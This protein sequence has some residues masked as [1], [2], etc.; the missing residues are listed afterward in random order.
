MQIQADNAQLWLFPNFIKSSQAQALFKHLQTEVQ[1]QQDQL[2]M[3]GK[4]VDIPRL[5]AW[6]GEKDANYA[7]SGLTMKPLPWL[8]VLA[9]LEKSLTVQC[10]T[11][12]NNN[13]DSRA[14]NFNSALANYYRDNNDA[15]G[16][17]SDDEP[18]LG[19]NPIIASVSLGATREFKLKHKITSEKLNIP[20]TS[21]SLL[22][23][24]GETQSY[25]QHAILRSKKVIAPRI[26]LTFRQIHP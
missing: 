19:I 6:F 12:I 13:G 18:E 15:V 5:Q 20:L 17:H 21:G 2:E 23:M 16:W 1:W 9:K 14:I 26:N 11:I 4:S 25:W 8:P 24:A 10:Q 3:Y 7:Y 22:L